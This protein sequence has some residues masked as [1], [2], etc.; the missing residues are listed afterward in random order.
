MPL[1][2]AQIEAAKDLLAVKSKCG[3]MRLAIRSI[4]RAHCCISQISSSDGAR[5]AS[6]KGTGISPWPVGHSSWAI[7]S[8]IR[9][10]AASERFSS[11]T[12]LAEIVSP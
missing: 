4:S 8:H 2:L 10:S 11:G 9:Y 3:C 7:I 5:S 1:P 6:V 12:L